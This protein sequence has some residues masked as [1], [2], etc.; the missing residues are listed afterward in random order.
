[1]GLGPPG[2]AEVPWP[3]GAMARWLFPVTQGE[4]GGDVQDEHV[5]PDIPG[6]GSEVRAHGD[7]VAFTVT[8]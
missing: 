8:R 7:A 6:T 3:G 2:G 4:H 5:E 1:V